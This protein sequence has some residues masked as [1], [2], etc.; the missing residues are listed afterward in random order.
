MVNLLSYSPHITLNEDN[1]ATIV[2]V[3]AGFSQQLRHVQRTQ[4]VSVG[5]IHERCQE[6]DCDMVYIET[7]KQ[8]GD[9]FT[10]GL[11]AGKLV[12][13]CKMIGLGR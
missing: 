2:V 1:Q 13:A 11:S 4:R 9:M 8:R 6:E 12:D 3:A 5:F 10:K 7:S